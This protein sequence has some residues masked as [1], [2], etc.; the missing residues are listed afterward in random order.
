MLSPIKASLPSRRASLSLHTASL[1]L[2]LASVSLYFPPSPFAC[3][4][5]VFHTKLLLSVLCLVPTC[6]L[7]F[8]SPSLQSGDTGGSGPPRCVFDHSCDLQEKCTRL[9]ERKSIRQTH[10]HNGGVG[11]ILIPYRLYQNAQPSTLR[12][13]CLPPVKWLTMM[14]NHTGIAPLTQ[15]Y[16]VGK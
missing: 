8:P 3:L 1:L 14:E 12:S 16:A 15:K 13:R 4:H 5:L 10:I 9:R 11:K 2:F 7:C 6:W